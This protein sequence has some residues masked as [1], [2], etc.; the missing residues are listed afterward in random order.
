M[1]FVGIGEIFLPFDQK[2]ALG[3]TGKLAHRGFLQF[4]QKPNCDMDWQKHDERTAR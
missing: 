2:T 4:R 1:P 3:G